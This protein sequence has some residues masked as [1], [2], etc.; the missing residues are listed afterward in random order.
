MKYTPSVS[1]EKEFGKKSGKKGQSAVT[2]IA[3]PTP[4]REL[5]W[6]ALGK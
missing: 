2:R 5:G 3:I 4:N 6:G 1:T